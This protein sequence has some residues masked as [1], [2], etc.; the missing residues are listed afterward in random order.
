MGTAWLWRTSAAS[1]SSVIASTASSRPLLLPLL[2]AFHMRLSISR[3]R[4][5]SLPAA[6]ISR[7]SYP[8]SI[9]LRWTTVSS[10]PLGSCGLS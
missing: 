3:P 7:S 2:S 4:A 8:R 5:V 6:F 10:E 1:W 9:A